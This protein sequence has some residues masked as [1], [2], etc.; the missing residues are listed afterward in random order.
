MEII[1]NHWDVKSLNEGN[2]LEVDIYCDK[3]LKRWGR[4]G[5]VQS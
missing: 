3:Y 2:I 5:G 4:Q 1:K